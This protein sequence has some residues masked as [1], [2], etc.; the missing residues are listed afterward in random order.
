MGKEDAAPSAHER[1]VAR[2]IEAF[3]ARNPE[4]CPAMITRCVRTAWK[5]PQSQLRITFDSPIQAGRPAGDPFLMQLD[6]RALVLVEPGQ[7]RM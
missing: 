5:D 1:Q 3:L 4:A 6:G 7:V 2:E